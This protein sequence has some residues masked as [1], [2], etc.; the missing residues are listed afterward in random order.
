MAPA[1]A[2]M[3]PES[4]REDR[5]NGN[6]PPDVKAN[7]VALDS[8]NML[9]LSDDELRDDEDEMEYEMSAAERE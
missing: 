7:P 1:A 2:E 9:D 5:S 6:R 4:K 3:L 8:N